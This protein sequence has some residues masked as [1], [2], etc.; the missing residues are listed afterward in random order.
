MWTLP[1]RSDGERCRSADSRFPVSPRLLTKL[2]PGSWLTGE[3]AA[4]SK[5]DSALP[6]P[7]GVHFS[8]SIRATRK[9]G[10]KPVASWS[11]R[12]KVIA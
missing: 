11:P 5:N 7:A 1:Y 9:T 4:E 6:H 12:R 10:L 3:N 2:H 8:P